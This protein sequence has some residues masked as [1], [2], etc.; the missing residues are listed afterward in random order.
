MEEKQT[1]KILLNDRYYK[2]WLLY[3]ALS[4][5]EIEKINID[6]ILCKL[7]SCDIFEY[8]ENIEDDE[9]TPDNK[10]IKILHSSVR[11]MPSIPGIL[12]LKN[13]KTYG[14]YK[15][16][17]LYKCIP[18]DKRIP[19]FL[20]PYA[21]K[22]GFSKNIDNKYIVFKYDNWD[23]KHPQG[24]IVNVLGDVDILANYYE[25]QLYCKSLYASI[26]KF[27]KDTS[28]ALKKQTEEEFITN[29]ITKYNLVD[30]TNEP[31][32]SIDSKQTTDYD[33]AFSIIDLGNDSYK[34]SIYIAN[35]PLWLE[36]LDLWNS[37]SDRIS[38][39][40]LPDRKRPMMPLILSNC[41]CSLCENVI[42]LAFTIDIIIKENE[43]VA[44]D[45]KNTYI[46][47]YK[48]H[49]YESKELKDDV[50]YKM[51]FD[52][53]DKLASVYKYTTKIVGSYD[54]VAYLMILM[55]Y[56]TATDMIKYHTGIYRSVIY[57]KEGKNTYNL[58]EDVN[59]FLK[60][61]NS[62]C[63]QYDMYDS[64]RAHEMLELE[65]YIHCT[66]PI[67]RLVDIL[68]MATLQENILLNKYSEN[69]REF[70]KKWTD[71]LEY[72][73]TTMRAIRKIQNE[74]N[75]LDMCINNPSLCDK[76]H[77]GYVFDKIIRNDGLYQYVVYLVELKTVFRITL[78][79]ELEDYNKYS[80]K[81]FIFNDEDS[82]KKKL[83]LHIVDN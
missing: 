32:Y 30:R 2:E 79:Y 5:N 42:R 25:Y 7:F 78:R 31:I 65:S 83:R 18:D 69:F 72:I 61:W 17:Y 80:F 33:D 11:S 58:P 20:V 43:I 57:D 62:S 77:E 49:V 51:M 55:N 29:M 40:Y 12:V 19:E 21:L 4:L 53:V 37:F 6:P 52:V 1:Y 34:L 3:D 73:N 36:E 44:Y 63:G 23:S 9:N 10:K 16:K 35:V 45:F 60:I 70:Y 82:L 74:C 81:I 54:M 50:N 66:S 39:I 14:K 41:L 64:R 22:L 68:N 47:V 38:T 28:N 48:N 75:L 24:T 27:N 56:Y 15:D 67:R 13:N 26:Q 59:N 76:K 8:N 71:N 46:K